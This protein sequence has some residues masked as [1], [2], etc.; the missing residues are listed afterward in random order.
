MSKS[1]TDLIAPSNVPARKHI[2]RPISPRMT[3]PSTSLSLA[4]PYKK[5]R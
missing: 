4:T 5:W 3:S 2:P 1:K